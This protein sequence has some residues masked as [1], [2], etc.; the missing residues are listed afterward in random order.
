MWPS[1]H[2]SIMVRQLS[3]ISCSVSPAPSATI[4]ASKSARW[5][6]TTSKKNAWHHHS[7]QADLGRLDPAGCESESIRINIVDTPGHADFGGEVER[8][9]S[10][11]DGVVLLVDSSEGAMPQ[12]KFVTGKALALGL[13][14]IVVVNKVDRNDARIQEV[15]DEVFDLFVSLGRKRRT[16]R[17]PRA[18]RLGPQRLCLDR[19][20]C[21]RRHADPDVR[22]DRQPRSRRPPLEVDGVPFTFLVTLARPRSLPRPHPHRPRQFGCR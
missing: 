4:S 18:L 13:K 9:L 3:S 1:S 17:F 14:P 22:D 21:A 11:V 10:M 16:A 20:G 6:R 19:H 8:I 7:R 12:T 2:T 5:I 15:L